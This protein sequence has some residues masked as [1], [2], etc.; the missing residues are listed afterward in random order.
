MKVKEFLIEDD[1]I[2]KGQKIMVAVAE[3]GSKWVVSGNPHFPTNL[4]PYESCWYT[5]IGHSNFNKANGK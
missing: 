2:N 1:F 4:I 3:D 5:E